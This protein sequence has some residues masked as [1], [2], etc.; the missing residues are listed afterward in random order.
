V[1][2]PQFQ[3]LFCKQFGCPP[4]EYERLAFRKCLYWH[5][6][7]LAP[8]ARQLKPDFFLQ[9]LKFLQELGAAT[10]LRETKQEM[11]NFQD[12]N[13]ARRSF[14]RTGLKIRVSGRKA[15]RLARR[16]FMA[17]NGKLDSRPVAAPTA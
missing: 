10:G 4:A 11:L 17:E 6:R 12:A 14:W 3:A 13:M 16:L 5:A 15:G 1:P 7:W 8:F 9:D 2:A